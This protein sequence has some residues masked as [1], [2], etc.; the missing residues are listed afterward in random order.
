MIKLN[1]TEEQIKEN[2][3]KLQ[4]KRFLSFQEGLS[5]G[6]EYYDLRHILSRGADFNFIVGMRDVGKTYNAKYW[7]L[8][9][10][11]DTGNEFVFI[12]RRDYEVKSIKESFFDDVA[13]VFGLEYKCKNSVYF[14]RAQKPLDLEDKEKK[15]WEKENPWLKAGMIIP[16]SDFQSFKGM[17]S[18]ANKIIFDEFIIDNLDHRYVNGHRE[19][20]VFLSLVDSIARQRQVRVVLISN[21]GQFSNPY[22][23]Y[24]NIT[25]SDLD[26]EWIY[27]EGRNVVF[28]NYSNERN[29]QILRKYTAAGRSGNKNYEKYALD[30][31]FTEIVDNQ[32]D[33]SII[34]DDEI[35]YLSTPSGKLL[36]LGRDSNGRFCLVNA[37]KVK[38]NLPVFSSSPRDNT[39]QYSRSRLTVL[40]EMHYAKRLSF[41]SV[42]TRIEFI[43]EVM[44]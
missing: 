5:I 20:E 35:Y 9:D 27:R 18:S 39:Y 32:V 12:K 17:V 7:A 22:F 38:N 24:Y 2:E 29:A 42:D 26:R 1:L 11:L 28:H 16:L 21:A 41:D 37:K 10:W 36:L 44:E 4:G 8:K 6:F 15:E 19:P 31:N 14:F 23:S 3:K 34:V 33:S 30:N 13:H 40:K 43:N 25:S